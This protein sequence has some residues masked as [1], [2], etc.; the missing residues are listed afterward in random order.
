[1]V[2]PGRGRICDEADVAEYRDMMTILR[3]RVADLKAKGKPLQAVVEARLTRD[4]D[5]RYS[6]PEWTGAMLVEAIYNTL[7][8][9]PLP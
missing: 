7:D 1:M 8:K 6:R 4:F 9:E 5:G 3:D 2:I